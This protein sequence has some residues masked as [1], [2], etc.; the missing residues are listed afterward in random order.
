[1]ARRAVILYDAKDRPFNATAASGWDAAG[2]GRRAKHWTPTSLGINQLLSGNVD[3]LRRRSRDVTRRNAWAQN[4]LDVFVAN[5]VGNGIR[6]KP[7]T[8]D[9]E[10]RREVLEAWDEWVEEA[11]ADGVCDFYGLQ[12]LV[13]RAQKEAGEC[14]VRFRPRRLEDGL[15]VPLQLQVLEADHLDSTFN[16]TRTAGRRIKAGIEFDAVGRRRAYHLWREHPGELLSLRSGQRTAVPAD[17]VIHVY[18]VVRPG[19]VR[20]IPG[21]A[22]ILSKLYELDQYDDAEVVRKKVAA[23]FAGF[24]RKPSEESNPLGAGGTEGLDS[25]DVPLAG[26]EPG[27]MQE[28]GPGEEITF[29]TP[30]DVGGAYEVFL[31]VQLR[32]VAMGLGVTY[33]QLTGDLTS[34]NF[35]SIR[36]GLNEFRRRMEQ[37]QRNVLIFQLCRRIWR[38]WFE[39]AVL[40]GRLRVPVG[41]RSQMRRLLRA[42]WQ[43]PGWEYVEPEK[44]VKAA[45]RRVRAGYSSRTREVA[46]LGCDAE[47][48]DREI[49]ADNERAKELGLILD[50]DPST[51]QDGEARAA[52]LQDPGQPGEPGEGGSA[53]ATAAADEIAAA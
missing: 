41:E 3:M 37:Y 25:D 9:D 40:S 52:A 15:S 34:V 2:V 42:A 38:R 13:C 46:K 45:V 18:Q 27:T 21:P 23:M 30:A 29:S 31:R 5:A 51:D 50:S 43:P 28:L 17:Q 24:V 48:L 1:M 10:F 35:S 49:A 32:A 4:G 26:L 44:D 11:D 20:G 39:V 33:E 16:E 12:A 47:E 7:N 14:F 22:T 19:Q 6:P 8:E 53:A 36:A